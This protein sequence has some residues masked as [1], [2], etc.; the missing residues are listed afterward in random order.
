MAKEIV[1]YE[2][3]QTFNGILKGT[4]FKVVKDSSKH[5]DK[6]IREGLSEETGIPE[7]QISLTNLKCFVVK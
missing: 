7:N 2:V 1:Y 6:C 5:I 4:R 3:G